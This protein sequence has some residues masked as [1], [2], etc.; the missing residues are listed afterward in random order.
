MYIVLQFT[1][2][3]EGNSIPTLQTQPRFS[4]LKLLVGVTN[5][6]FRTLFK[7]H[8]YNEKW[9]HKI[10]FLCHRSGVLVWPFMKRG[11]HWILLQ[12]QD[13]PMYIRLPREPGPNEGEESMQD[14]YQAFGVSSQGQRWT[15]L[16]ALPST[17]EM[18]QNEMFWETQESY[19]N[20]TGQQD[21]GT[22][23]AMPQTTVSATLTWKVLHL[24]VCLHCN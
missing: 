4:S 8:F 22:Q 2:Y 3:S 15:S 23:I 5:E 7:R 20:K 12:T 11:A 17:Q 14:T 1:C 10:G 16:S 19:V 21:Y 13:S 6:K 18:K 9:L 24:W